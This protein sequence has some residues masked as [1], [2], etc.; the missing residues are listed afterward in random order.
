MA[1]KTMKKTFLPTKRGVTHCWKKITT[2]EMVHQHQP[3]FSSTHLGQH[4][5]KTRKQQTRSLFTGKKS[6]CSFPSAISPPKNTETIISKP[7]TKKVKNAESEPTRPPP[8]CG[9]H[10]SPEKCG[11]ASELLAQSSPR[12][13]CCRSV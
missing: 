4:I 12:K 7:Y 10:F 1:F 3:P 13:G 11:A 9:K 8:H 5:V 2:T 6:C